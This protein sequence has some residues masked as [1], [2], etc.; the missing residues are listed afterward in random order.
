VPRIRSTLPWQV[1]LA[2][3][4]RDVRF[5]EITDALFTGWDAGAQ[6]SA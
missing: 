3:T 1:H 6:Q 5:V 4:D 2:V